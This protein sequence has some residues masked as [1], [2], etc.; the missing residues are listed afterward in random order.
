MLSYV[1]KRRKKVRKYQP[2]VQLNVQSLLPAAA[3]QQYA[4]LEMIKGHSGV[5]GNERADHIAKSTATQIHNIVYDAI[6][7]LQGKQ[8][9]R[10]YYNKI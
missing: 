3:R 10:D 1:T 7:I 6:P 8:L 5:R 9:V 2:Q 4:K